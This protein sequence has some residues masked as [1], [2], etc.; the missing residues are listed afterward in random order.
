MERDV[1][2]GKIC[3][4]LVC[5]FNGSGLKGSSLL[6]CIVILLK[7]E[8]RIVGYYTNKMFP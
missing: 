5:D 6:C 4:Y 8:G 7:V 1:K 3:M 2:G